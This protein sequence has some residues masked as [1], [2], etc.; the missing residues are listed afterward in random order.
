MRK[1]IIV[2]KV[3][4]KSESERTICNI[5]ESMFRDIPKRMLEHVVDL[6]F[7]DGHLNYQCIIPIGF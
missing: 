3:E 6:F 4:V 7:I 1:V 2:L 5:G